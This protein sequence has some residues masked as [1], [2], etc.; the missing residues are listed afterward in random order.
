MTLVLSTVSQPDYERERASPSSTE[1]AAAGRDFRFLV[2]EDAGLEVLCCCLMGAIPAAGLCM[3]ML[4][5][6]SKATCSTERR[7]LWHETT[8]TGPMTETPM[9]GS[10]PDSVSDI[11]SPDS[12][13][14]SWTARLS[15]RPDQF[16]LGSP[17][18]DISSTYRISALT[19]RYSRPYGSELLLNG[20]QIS[21]LKNLLGDVSS[22]FG[23]VWTQVG[24]IPG[25]LYYRKTKLCPQISLVDL[26]LRE[27]QLDR[28]FQMELQS[29]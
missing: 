22:F 18:S 6:C 26:L 16:K 12:D 7:H 4:T 20:F 25:T 24:S 27:H 3:Q 11:S 2:V 17:R 23:L 9:G 8:T 1:G 15:Q 28:L 14:S 19:S 29:K 5:C 21:I 10:T 13:G